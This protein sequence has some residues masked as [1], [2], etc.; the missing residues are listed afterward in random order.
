MGSEYA[1]PTVSTRDHHDAGALV[2]SGVDQRTRRSDS[3][4]ADNSAQSDD[5]ADGA[6]APAT[7]LQ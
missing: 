5:R 3:K 2:A 6:G 1:S 7:A 4:H